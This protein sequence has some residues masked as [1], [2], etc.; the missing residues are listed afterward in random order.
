MQP[1]V[2]RWRANWL[3]PRTRWRPRNGSKV[4]HRNLTSTMID[5]RDFLNVKKR[6]DNQVL[7]YWMVKQEE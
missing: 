2:Q 7:A 1:R 5:S 4:N 6:A 3:Q